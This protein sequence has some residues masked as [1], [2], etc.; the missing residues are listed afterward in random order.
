MKKTLVILAAAILLAG[1]QGGQ[2]GPKAAG[3]KIPPEAAGVWKQVIRDGEGGNLWAMEITED[4]RVSWALIELAGAIVKPGQVTKTAMA[5]GQFS[6]FDTSPANVGYDPKTRE[7]TVSFELKHLEVRFMKEVIKGSAKYAFTGEV[8]QDGKEWN[9]IFAEDF[10]YGP[11]FPM[12]PNSIGA[13]R[14]FVKMPG[15]Y[16]PKD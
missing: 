6:T 15:T 9:V 13:S 3:V 10:D 5:D 4:G 8:S 12:D 11:R 16:T 7:L 1:C 2:K 14:I